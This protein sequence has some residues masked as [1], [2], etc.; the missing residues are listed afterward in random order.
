MAVAGNPTKASVPT[1]AGVSDK[2][3]IEYN[4]LQPENAAVSIDVTELG[5]VKE[6]RLVQP[7]NAYCLI[8]V[9]EFGMVKSVTNSLSMYRLCP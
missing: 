7:S 2:T 3:V 5:M 9:M 4:S 1:F 6:L 8:E